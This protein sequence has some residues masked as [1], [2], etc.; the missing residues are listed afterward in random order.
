MLRILAAAC[1]SALEPAQFVDLHRSEAASADHFGSHRDWEVS[2][3]LLVALESL[4]GVRALFVDRRFG[5][6]IEHFARFRGS[7]AAAR[8]EEM[9]AAVEAHISSNPRPGDHYSLVDRFADIAGLHGLH[10][11][12]TRPVFELEELVGA[13]VGASGTFPLS[14]PPEDPWLE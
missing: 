10:D 12:D 11:W 7:P 4:E 3:E 14:R 8:A 13:G 2:P 1:V 5:G 9:Y 6:T